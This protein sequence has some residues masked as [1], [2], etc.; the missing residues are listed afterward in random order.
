MDRKR[1][2]ELASIRKGEWD[3]FA[4]NAGIDNK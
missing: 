2:S 1:D 4:K 3:E